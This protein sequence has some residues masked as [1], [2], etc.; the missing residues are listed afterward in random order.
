MEWTKRKYSN[1][2]IKYAKKIWF[3]SLDNCVRHMSIFYIYRQLY[4]T[5]NVVTSIL[6]I[7][8]VSSYYQ[9]CYINLHVI[10]YSMKIA[11]VV[12]YVTL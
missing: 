8:F 11:I 12:V 2:I 10:V 1:K 6:D 4:S 3:S 9:N 5:N 7:V